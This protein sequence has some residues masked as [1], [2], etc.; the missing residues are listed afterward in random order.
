MK[1]AQREQGYRYS[2]TLKPQNTTI[3]ATQKQSSKNQI[4]AQ[5][6][7]AQKTAKNTAAAMANTQ[8]RHH[9]R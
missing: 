9:H 4:K 8:E 5:T 2:Q 3:A 6:A 1:Q 7:V